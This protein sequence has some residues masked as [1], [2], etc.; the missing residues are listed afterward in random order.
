[1]YYECV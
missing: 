1:M